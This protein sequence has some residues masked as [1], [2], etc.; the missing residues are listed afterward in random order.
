MAELRR[1]AE[2]AE[3]ERDALRVRLSPMV[4]TPQAAPAAPEAPTVVIVE[5]DTLQ[6]SQGL[7]TR[8]RRALRG[9]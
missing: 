8:L 3:A 7:W 6:R 2:G 1:R 4:D 9:E 5:A